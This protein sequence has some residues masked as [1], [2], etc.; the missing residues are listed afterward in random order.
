MLHTFWNV[1]K[2]RHHWK[3]IWWKN[4][5]KNLA[6]LRRVQNNKFS[7]N[8][9][10]L[11]KTPIF[12]ISLSF[13]K[14]VALNPCLIRHHLEKQCKHVLDLRTNHNTSW[15][16]CVQC[17]NLLNLQPITSY[18]TPAN[19]DRTSWFKHTAAKNQGD[20]IQRKRA[21]QDGEKSRREYL[22]I[23]G[24]RPSRELPK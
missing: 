3:I 16:S 22:R 11:P 24:F 4:M 15:R 19:R 23:W 2:K 18:A 13:L 21:R 10:Q 8:C 1:R 6:L 17:K 5:I 20:C 12:L 14:L 7:S 9:H